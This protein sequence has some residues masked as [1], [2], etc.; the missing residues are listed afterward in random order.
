MKN[1]LKGTLAVSNLLNNKYSYFPRLPQITRVGTINLQYHFGGKSC[2]N[3]AG[4]RGLSGGSGLGKTSSK[5]DS[6]GDGIKDSKDLCPDIAGSRK[7]KGCPKDKAEMDADAAAAEAARL[8][9]EKEAKLKAEM[10]A[11]AK[12]EEEAA[13]K[14]KA[15]MEAKKK[16]E[17]EAAAKK[18]AEAEAVAAKLK[19]EEEA[20]VAAAEAAKKAEIIK[21]ETS[22]VF[23]EALTGIQFNSALSTLKTT[24]YSSLDNVVEVMNKYPE[25]SVT[26]EGHTDSQGND[27]SNMKL[28]Q[29]RA[30]T[31][32][33]YLVSKGIS[34]DRLKAVGF[35]ELQPIA[36]NKT[37]EGRKQNRRVAFKVN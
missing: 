37:A 1:G 11:K 14:K 33:N 26:I 12:A 35:G 4:T 2:G 24:S 34:V 18:K 25:I 20:K 22:R 31:V 16:A 30:I 17:E 6:D 13:A 21:T 23:N 15:A 5:M 9:A 10:E 28:S 29:E 8:K 19:A 27:D 3:S 32:L 36:D 7:F